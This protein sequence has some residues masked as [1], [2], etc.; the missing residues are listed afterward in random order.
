MR[1]VD[2]CVDAAAA[3]VSP[4]SRADRHRAFDPAKTAAT[5]K[6]KQLVAEVLERLEKAER[7]QRRRRKA[8]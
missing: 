4:E 3:A 5:S 7:R 8:D 6:S 1:V 2:F